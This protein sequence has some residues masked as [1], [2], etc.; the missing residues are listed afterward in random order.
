MST[1][2]WTALKN[3]STTERH[4][5]RES[6]ASHHQNTAEACGASLCEVYKKF[7]QDSPI[8]CE[9]D[10]GM[11]QRVLFNKSPHPQIQE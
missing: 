4:G 8:F 7:R 1:R 10:G 3:K 5:A 2:G 11:V 9:K 6:Q